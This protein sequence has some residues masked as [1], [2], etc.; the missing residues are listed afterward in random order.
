M[1]QFEALYGR[2]CNTSVSWDNPIDRAVVRPYFFKEMEEQMA[3]IKQNLKVLRDRQK[4]NANKNKVFKYFKTGEHVFIKVKAKRSSITLSSWPKL[5]TRSCGSF[6]ILKNIDLV[7]YM[8]ELYASMRVHNVFH[9]S[10]L[11]K[12]VPDPNHIIDWNVI[13]VEHEMDF[14]VEPIHIC[15]VPFQM[16]SRE[17]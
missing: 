6:E 7:A 2:K 1:S 12:Y 16:S 14:R 8:L 5:A 3:K 4:N 10:L 9:V 15:N 11:K 17:N 13:Q